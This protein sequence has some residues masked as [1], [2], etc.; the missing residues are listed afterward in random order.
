MCDYS[1]AHFPNRLAVE[2]EQLVVHRFDTLAI[3]LAPAYPSLKERIFPTTLPAVCVPPGARLL[4][5][6]IPAYIREELSVSE[7]EEV[8]F[9]EQTAEAFRFR[10]AVRFS[11]GQEVLLQL[12]QPGQRV[13][14]LSVCGTEQQ[15]ESQVK[16]RAYYASPVPAERGN[17]L[18][19]FE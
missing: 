19:P 9:V 1:L 14:V 11:D 13:D 12:L 10:D 16:E 5:S 7:V 15:I 6:D 17:F 3:G 18:A 8:T 4:L 2:G